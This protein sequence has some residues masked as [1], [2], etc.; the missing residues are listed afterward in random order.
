MISH[1]FDFY[2]DR[3]HALVEELAALNKAHNISVPGEVSSLF[4]FLC[5]CS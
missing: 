2:S 3:E 5:C 1:C 4:S